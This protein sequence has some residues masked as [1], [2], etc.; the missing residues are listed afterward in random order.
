MKY[1][2]DTNEIKLQYPNLDLDTLRILVYSDASF[3]NREENKSQLGY[4]ILL[5]DASNRCAVL[6]YSSQKSKRVTRSSMGAETLAFV[7]AFDSALLIKNDLNRMINRDLPIVMMTDSEA[8]FRILTRVRYTTERRLEID[9]ASAREAYQTREISNIAW[10]HS[11]D[12]YAD[13]LT[14]LDGNGSL[15]KLLQNHQIDHDVR[16]WIIEKPENSTSQ[17]TGVC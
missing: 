5:S 15:L 3:N 8:L 4:I 12:N 6:H 7:D 2:K 14:K 11:E 9:I 10:I 1:L 13:D 17:K 16:Q